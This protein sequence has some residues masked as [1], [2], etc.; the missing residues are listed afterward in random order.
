MMAESVYDA[1]GRVTRM[2]DVPEIGAP[3]G[4]GYTEHLYYVYTYN[5]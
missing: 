2:D 3:D 4:A 5:D 1:H